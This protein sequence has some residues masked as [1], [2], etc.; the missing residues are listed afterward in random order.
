[1]S[2]LTPAM[3]LSAKKLAPG[4]TLEPAVRERTEMLSTIKRERNLK[5]ELTSMSAILSLSPEEGGVKRPGKLLDRAA[6]G[7]FHSVIKAAGKVGVKADNV[8]LK[9]ASTEARKWLAH[10][11]AK[12]QAADRDVVTRRKRANAAWIAEEA[13]LALEMVALSQLP[14]DDRSAV[15]AV[16]LQERVTQC[17]V[18][19][20]LASEGECVPPK[21]KGES[22]SFFIRRKKG[23][24]LLYIF[25]PMEG[26]NVPRVNKD[27]TK[28]WPVGGGA[29][30]EVAISR[31][32][33]DMRTKLGMDFGVA[34]T[35][36]V[37][38][39]SETFTQGTKSQ[40]VKRT[41]ALQTA[42]AC[43]EESPNAWCDV[44]RSEEDARPDRTEDQIRAYKDSF[45]LDDI[46]KIAVLDFLTLNLDRNPGNVL[47]TR[48]A[49]GS[50]SLSPIDAGNCLPT[51]EIFKS[52]AGGMTVPMPPT[53]ARVNE[54]NF[55]AQ[56]PKSMEPLTGPM[57]AR[58]QALNPREVGGSMRA[59]AGS[60]EGEMAGKIDESS[61]SLVEASAQF[62]KSAA[63]LPLAA[64]L[65]PYELSVMY[66]TTFIAYQKLASDPLAP[67]EVAAT[68]SAALLK[69]VSDGAAAARLQMAGDRD[70][71]EYDELGGAVK[72]G[73][74]GYDARLGTVADRIAILRAGL[75]EPGCVRRREA[76]L[77]EVDET[78]ESIVHPTKL[79]P[80]FGDRLIRNQL[81]DLEYYKGLRALGGDAALARAHAELTE[82]GVADL[83]PI[84]KMSLSDKPNFL[85]AYQEL[86]T[87]LG[88]PQYHRYVEQGLI[89]RAA[90]LPTLMMILSFMRGAKKKADALARPK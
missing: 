19:K 5:A 46:Q 54:G 11:D 34:K 57:L 55:I 32:N 51:P 22:D 2:R 3:A 42:I 10:D 45:K 50:R 26:E 39:D 56:L 87:L 40:A 27:V 75:P 83:R 37:Q 69:L 53:S 15:R 18:H 23:G 31:F 72:L 71:A 65:S 43:N 17:E 14:V 36:A 64:A 30:R 76:L 82:L 47:V 60:L 80:Q 78:M 48:N 88:I 74:L 86:Q 44:D 24:R 62:L 85:S 41:G 4:Y 79:G 28:G 9:A 35:I 77:R 33:D 89:P 49:D 66:S 16:R 59:A 63:S 8:A 6:Y 67:G 52:H 1:M 58:L 81:E 21:A 12:L 7:T 70:N 20:M 38:L 84:D 73:L 25:K 61:L 90:K 68:R 29:P 13:D